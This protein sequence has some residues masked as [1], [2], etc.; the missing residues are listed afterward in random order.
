VQFG[1]AEA[2]PLADSSIDLLFTS[3]PYAS[4][5]I[6][7]MRAHKFS[8]VWFGKHVD[9]LSELRSRYIGGENVTSFPFM[10][11]PIETSQVIRKVS[12]LDRKKALALHRYY[13]EM[14]RVLIQTYRVLKPGKSALFVVG[15]SVMRGVDT[16][17]QDCLGEIG[18]CL[19]LEHIGTGVRRIDRDRRMM[20]ARQN[21]RAS[22]IEQRMHE[23]Y[24]V[25]F[26]KP[27]RTEQNGH[28]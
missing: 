1:N 21:G 28:N 12:A 6:D 24:V 14:K 11:M 20:P 8:L 13:S 23:E 25:A 19:G 27:E 16:R 2:L 26:I 10:E 9:E 18:S 7:Y 22:Q 17:T 5:A 3:P 15:S 4:T